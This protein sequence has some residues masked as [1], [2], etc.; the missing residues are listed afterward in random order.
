MQAPRKLVV[1]GGG[2]SGFFCAVNAARM[3]PTLEVV[4]LEKSRHLLSKVRVSG[5]GRC[6]VTHA[7]ADIGELAA[8][9]PRGQRFL[10]KAFHWF[11]TQHTIAWFEERGIPL[12]T[13]PDGRMFPQSN[14]SETIIQCLLR[15]AD[16]YRVQVI[17]QC[18]TT[19]IEKTG[20][21]FHLSL[22]RQG[23]P[24]ST[25]EADFLLL[26]CGGFPKAEQFNWILRLGHT[27]ETPVPSLFTFNIPGHPVLSLMGVSVERAHVKITGTQLQ[28]EGPLLIT[29][30]GL[31]GPAVLK[32][33]AWGAR[34]LAEKN[35]SFDI[36]VNWVPSFNEQTLSAEWLRLRQELASSTLGSRNPFGL[37]A[38]LW[39]YLLMASGVDGATRWADLPGKQQQNLIRHLVIHPFSVKG[40]T[41]FKE[42]FVTCGGISLAGID[43][44]RMES[45]K[46]PGLFFAGELMDVDG[47]T[48]GF[49]FQHA[50]TSGWI[51]ANAIVNS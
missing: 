43:V 14:T 30:W 17:C 4:I 1:I 37:P 23:Q 49:N 45:K 7:A 27:L 5:G 12:K 20:A 39:Q 34:I 10:R 33:S 28:Q 48:G 44:N 47:I 8:C 25:M 11:N 16:K 6:N 26:A 29:H 24:H 32:L 38:R 18:E 41:T 22:S 19:A 42:E 36:V 9:Y 51:A 3:D 40:K 21:K 2:A 46:L 35:Y 15:E 50:W 31:S 13:E